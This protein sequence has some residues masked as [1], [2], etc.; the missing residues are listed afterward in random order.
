MPE[1]CVT[2]LKFTSP[3]ANIKSYR[4]Y[5]PAVF[6]TVGVV[7]VSL[8]ENP[9]LPPAIG[10]SDKL[11]HALMY[12]LLAVAWI[13]PV[14]QCLRASA[15]P[16]IFMWLGVTLFGALME[17]LQHWCTRTRSGDWA[18]VLA[19]AIG[20]LLGIAVVALWQWRYAKK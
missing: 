6:L 7:M 12:A 2:E 3:I 16:Y 10:E 17:I 20:A 5:I 13:I 4:T 18:D 14:K 19:D 8:W 1:T 9:Q 15:W 11:M